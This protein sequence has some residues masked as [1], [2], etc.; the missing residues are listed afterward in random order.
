MI[1]VRCNSIVRFNRVYNLMKSKLKS[2]HTP[3]VQSNPNAGN[4]THIISLQAF[5]A[6]L[7]A[8][9]ADADKRGLLSIHIP[10]TCHK[11]H[12]NQ[13]DN[14]LGTYCASRWRS[15]RCRLA[16]GSVQTCRFCSPQSISRKL[17]Q[18]PVKPSYRREMIINCASFVRSLM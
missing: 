18:G 2:K 16:G 10:S 8:L 11:R 7:C 14:T 13:T 1:N 5:T 4:N 6:P 3:Q 9:G 12:F 17:I 15:Y